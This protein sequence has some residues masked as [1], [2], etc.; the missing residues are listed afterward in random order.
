M[1]LD[2]Q[3]N[4]TDSA[5]IVDCYS[6]EFLQWGAVDTTPFRPITGHYLNGPIQPVIRRFSIRPEGEP[7]GVVSSI[8]EFVGYSWD[9][10]NLHGV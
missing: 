4:R 6:E 9:R 2:V 10:T 3:H 7:A 5:C 8:F 1:D